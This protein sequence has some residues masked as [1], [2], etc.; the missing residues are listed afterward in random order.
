MGLYAMNRFRERC[1]LDVG[2]EHVT[3]IR[4]NWRDALG[5][6]LA[7]IWQALW[8]PWCAADM[9]GMSVPRVSLYFTTFV[10]A[11]LGVTLLMLPLPLSA[12]ASIFQSSQPQAVYCNFPYELT[13]LALVLALGRMY[14]I[15][16]P[17]QEKHCCTCAQGLEQQTA[18]IGL[19]RPWDRP[20]AARISTG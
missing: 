16:F 15:A 3:M 11:R 13:N 6:F 1:L 14:C 17:A 18:S 4:W 10:I 9:L 5:R 20:W 12:L 19:H 8:R 7:S 2:M